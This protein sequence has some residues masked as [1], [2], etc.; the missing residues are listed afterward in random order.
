MNAALVLGRA[1]R[2]VILLDNGQPRNAVTHESHGFI[3]RDGV[4]PAEFR[5]IAVEE[6]LRYPS[7]KHTQTEVTAVSKTGA[8]FEMQTEQGTRIQ[9]R[10][11]IL[12]TG[13]KE[14][15]P[16]IEGFHQ[17]YGKSLFN[18]PYCDG[19]ELR[20]SLLVVV[21]EKPAAFHM[22]K[23]VLNWSK[24]L[25]VCTN[26][27]PVLTDEQKEKL[28]S[29]GVS[30]FEKPIAAFT[31]TNGRLDQIRFTDGTYIHRTGGFITPQLTPKAG[32]GEKLGCELTELG[33]VK[34]DEFGRSSVPGVYAAGDSAYVMPSSLILAAAAGSL[35]ASGVNMDLI[36]ED[37]D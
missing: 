34:T 21:S 32:F 26:G 18:C 29:K 11:L 24:D 35:T 17:M 22:A 36:E 7:V 6:V 9:S 4:K 37:F 33:G 19:W 13:L 15:F 31:G 3:T 1:R 8:G 20:D 2:S 28:Q 25:V 14:T 23:L 12:A 30:V 16:D 27:H 5:R 10:K